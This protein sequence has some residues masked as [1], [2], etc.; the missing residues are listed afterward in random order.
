MKTWLDHIVI[1]APSLQAGADYV[2]R[3]LGVRMHPGGRHAEMGTHN[4]LLRLGDDVFLE[5]I[6][7]DPSA[8][9]P[10]HARWFGM[11]HA[12]KIRDDWEEGRR[13]R[14]WVART[15][16]LDPLLASEGHW[17]GRK[18]RVSRGDRQWDF[19][20]RPDGAW[21]LDGA[22]PC[23][24]DWGPRGNPAAAMPD[25]S[26]K[27]KALTLECPDVALIERVY[28]RLGLVDPPLLRK[29]ART[30]L[31]AQIETPRGLIELR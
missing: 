26:A 9:E 13:L 29:S 19:A 22:A 6:A 5:V 20:V 12:A 4:L 3:I 1:V 18:M 17:L 2:A 15:E 14:G 23:V 16:D 30:R 21:P 8:A 27:L 24:I 25:D 10:R 11:D 28:K 7:V 31:I